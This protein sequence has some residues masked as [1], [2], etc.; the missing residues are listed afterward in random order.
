MTSNTRWWFRRDA[1]LIRRSCWDWFPR[2]GTDDGVPQRRPHPQSPWTLPPTCSK[3]CL[4]S[5]ELLSILDGNKSENER[6]IPASR[7][8]CNLL[9]LSRFTNLRDR[10][11]FWRAI[12]RHRGMDR[13]RGIRIEEMVRSDFNISRIVVYWFW[14]WLS[15]EF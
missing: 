2:R 7:G 1:R 15:F 5:T 10:P 14:F 9:V 12:G 11:S 6:R 8:K 3:D 4:R 13:L